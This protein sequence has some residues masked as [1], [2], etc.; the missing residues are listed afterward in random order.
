MMI[1]EAAAVM[2]LTCKRKRGGSMVEFA[3]WSA[4][5]LF[6]DFLI[7]AFLIVIKNQ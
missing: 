2:K 6:F 5:L 3:I 4:N 7:I 1:D